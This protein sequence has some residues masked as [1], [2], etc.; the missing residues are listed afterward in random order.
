MP[1]LKRVFDFYIFSN[2]HVALAVFC[3]VKITLLS[4]GNSSD[5]IP[6][7]C[8]FSTIASYNLIRIF[9][10]EEVQPWFYEFIKNNKLILILFTVF[11]A[12]V[13]FLLIFKF[14][15][16][17]L[18]WFIPFGIITLFYV[19]PFHIKEQKISLRYIAFVK[20]FLI[21][22]SW[23]AVTVIIPLVQHRI[24]IGNNEI[25][26]FV[27]RFLFVAAITIPFDIR[28]ITYDK[29]ELK[30]L[31]Q[32]I[33]VPK[34]K[35]LGLLFLMLFLGLEFFKTTVVPEQLRIHF[36]IAVIT[37]LFLV[38]STEEQHKYYSAFFVESLPMV[39]LG[40][41]IWLR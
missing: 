31:P 10:I 11:S 30:T 5:I 20:L 15:Y 14:R 17:T 3:L 25:I 24:H 9:R 8:F 40:L 22:I 18:F 35:W 6:L 41:F 28:D 36:F 2:I 39:W 23:A 29:D 26:L 37:L 16:A 21:A 34:S 33:G 12:V 1:L 32:A 4:Y 19:N 27:Q 38:K 7:F 13:A